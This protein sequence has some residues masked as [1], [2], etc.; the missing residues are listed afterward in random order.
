MPGTRVVFSILYMTGTLRSDVCKGSSECA[1][2]S[3]S[4][5]CVFLVLKSEFKPC[6]GS[7]FFFYFFLKYFHVF[8]LPI[9]FLNHSRVKIKI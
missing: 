2:S 1:I 5:A 7:Y 6:F 3:V 8:F 4:M 9:V